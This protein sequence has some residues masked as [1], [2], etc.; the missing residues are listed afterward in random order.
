MHEHL[1][2]SRKLTIFYIAGHGRSGSTLLEAILGQ[3][4]G[5][6]AVGELRHIWQR[7]LDENQLCG[8]GSPFKRCSFWSSVLQKVFGSLSTLDPLALKEL[9]WRVDRTRY[10]PQMLLTAKGS[11]YEKRFQRYL[12]IRSR[13][14][15]AISDVSGARIIVDSSKDPSSLYAL[16]KQPNVRVCVIH[17]V[18]DSRAVSYSWQRKKRRPEITSAVAYMPTFP[19]SRVAIEWMMR[20]LIVELSRPLVSAYTLVRYEDFVVEPSRV[21]NNLLASV[22]VGPL[23]ASIVSESR[24]RLARANHTV[25]GNPIRF[26]RGELAIRRDDE[27][28]K[29]LPAC[30]R[31]AV[32]MLTLPGL[33]RYGYLDLWRRPLTAGRGTPP[34]PNGAGS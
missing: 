21:V 17:L 34:T 23:P 16:S 26:G 5:V 33:L 19:P 20:N 2:S 28:R 13:L 32:T 14:Y 1:T 25:A 11:C 24:A 18:R 3:A 15:N 6:V 10:I 8:C 7:G 9:K 30:Q 12:D 4:R 27:W 22:G 29:K 31:L